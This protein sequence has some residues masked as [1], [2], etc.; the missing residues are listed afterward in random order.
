MM[1]YCKFVWKMACCIAL[2]A[3]LS[4]AVCALAEDAAP[5]CG[6]QWVL[7]TS[8]LEMD[9][10]IEQ[11]NDSTH[12]WVRSY[13]KDVC[14]LCGA[15][16]DVWLASKTSQPHA[17]ELAGWSGEAESITMHLQCHLC[18]YEK[19]WTMGLE[20]ILTSEAAPCLHGGQCTRGDRGYMDTQGKIV[21]WTWSAEE[22]V[23][24]VAVI[25]DA[26]EQTFQPVTRHYCSVCG[27]P[28][29]DDTL[30]NPQTEFSESWHGLPIMTEEDFLT[31]DMT[32]NLPYQLIDQLRKEAGAA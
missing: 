22:Q 10:T 16:G 5:E 21:P 7:F 27:R 14:A 17:F 6:H 25:Y 31:V 32:D 19:D 13:P 9:Q 8:F 29:Y 12:N 2:I 26:D 24:L 1:P 30:Q 23:R 15:Y 3:A 18:G 28:G 20:A 4:M 11:G